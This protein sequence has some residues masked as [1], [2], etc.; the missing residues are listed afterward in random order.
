[1][2]SNVENNTAEPLTFEVV[3]SSTVPPRRCWHSKYSPIWTALEALPA[4]KSL[5]FPRLSSNVLQ[6]IR[7]AAR[8]FSRRDGKRGLNVHSRS[9]PDA[10]YIW[11]SKAD[12]KPRR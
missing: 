3:D 1:M 11:T 7:V 9:T 10:T 2:K 5:K 12:E 6:A 8:I 4:N